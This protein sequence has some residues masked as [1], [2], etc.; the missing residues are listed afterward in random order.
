[1]PL[2]QS[3]TNCHSAVDMNDTIIPSER[4]LALYQ[5]FQNSK[6]FKHSEGT[7]TH[8]K[9]VKVDRLNQGRSYGANTGRLANHD[10]SV[11]NRGLWNPAE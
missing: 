6:L 8:V 7:S 4:T 1:M 11:H 3:V 2:D 10:E 9:A 5:L